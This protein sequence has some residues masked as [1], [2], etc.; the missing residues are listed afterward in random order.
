[1]KL[2]EIEYISLYWII[3]FMCVDG[4]GSYT[5]A[6]AVPFQDGHGWHAFASMIWYD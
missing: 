1:M 3:L 4:E 6:E 5:P 2:I